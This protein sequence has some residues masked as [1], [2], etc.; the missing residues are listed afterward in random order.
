MAF[1][2]K[3]SR[4][5]VFKLLFA[6]SVDALETAVEGELP[7]GPEMDY[8]NNLFKAAIDNLDAIDTTI[9]ELSMGFTIDRIFKTDLAALRLGIAE[10]RY[11]NTNPS[12]IINEV[13]EIAKRYGTEKSS[14]FVNGILSR[15]KR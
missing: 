5:V 10:I 4:E 3:K 14:G 11:T 8:I 1:S 13:V 9:S 6:G 12:V 15:V 2:R 7:D